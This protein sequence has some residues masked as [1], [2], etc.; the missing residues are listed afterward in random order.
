MHYKEQ[1]YCLL[2]YKILKITFMKFANFST[3]AL[4]FLGITA[5][6]V[7]CKKVNVPDEMGDAGQ[8]LVKMIT[9]D[10]EFRLR[11]IDLKNQ[12]QA[13]KVLDVRRDVPNGGELNKTMTIVIEE[14]QTLVED[15][16]DVHGTSYVALPADKYT[17]DAANP[18]TGANWTLTMAPGEFAKGVFI[19]VPNSLDL[20][21]SQTYAFGFRIKT[22]DQN[23]RISADYQTA[24][25]EIGVKNQYDGKYRLNG[26]FYHPTSSPLYASFTMDAELHTTGAQSVKIYIPDFGGYYGP[27]LFSGSLSAFNAQEPEYTIDPVTNKIVAQNGYDGAVTFYQMNPDYD[28]HY[29]PATRTLYVKYGYN[30]APGPVF[31]PAANREWTYELVY[32]GPR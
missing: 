7:G 22:V 9:D 23:G 2:H 3:K 24:V 32:V 30:Y 15:Y 11:A 10:G 20:D 6:A 5:L 8:T 14:D 25:V 13:I 29:D 1:A 28:S 12:P 31:N 26:A 16:N 21:L 19:T 27:G 4:L 18:R 17:V